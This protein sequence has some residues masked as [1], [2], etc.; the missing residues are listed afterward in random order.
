MDRYTERSMV[1]LIDFDRDEGRAEY[2]KRRIPERLSDRVFVL[3]ALTDPEAL[4]RAGLGSYESSVRRSPRIAAK[5]QTTLGRMSSFDTTPTRLPVCGNTFGRSYFPLDTRP[6]C[7]H[8]MSLGDMSW[9]GISA[10]RSF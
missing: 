2:A 3:G 7:R 5:K 1:L 4:K 6:A 10:N 9:N 8:N